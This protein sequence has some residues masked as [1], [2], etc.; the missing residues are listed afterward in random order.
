VIV[1]GHSCVLSWW[2]AVRKTALP[3][4]FARYASEVRRGLAEADMIVAPTHA[5]LEALRAH[6][7]PLGTAA[8]VPNGRDPSLFRPA[9]KEP[10]VLGAGRF[11][12]EAKNLVVL[13]RAARG[14]AWPVYVAG[15]PTHPQ[16]VALPTRHVRPLGRL[17]PE[18]LGEWMGRA[19]I[20]ALPARYEPFGLS[21]LEAALAGCALVL[22]DLASLRET[23][24]GAAVWVDPGD[25]AALRAALARLVEDERYRQEMSA[26]ARARASLFTPARMA[27]GY[28]RAYALVGG[29]STVEAEACAS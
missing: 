18:T 27:E 12:D 15:A 3:S 4:V 1:V 20:Y 26:R 21:V 25:I 14:L 13:D 28:L 2:A 29:A 11:W 19:A 22:G 8:V 10:I 7:G 6:Y 24:D 9:P 23:W 5:M 16:G 17:G